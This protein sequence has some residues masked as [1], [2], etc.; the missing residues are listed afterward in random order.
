MTYYK[1]KPCSWEGTEIQLIYDTVETCMG[2]DKIE[3][4]PRCGNMDVRL[5]LRS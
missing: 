2:T 4:C 3:L 1:C 5:I